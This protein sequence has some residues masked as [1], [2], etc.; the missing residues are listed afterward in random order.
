M[1]PITIEGCCQSGKTARAEGGGQDGHR[2]WTDIGN[3][4]EQGR[5]HTPEHDVGRPM[6][7]RPVASTIP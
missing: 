7:Y 2:D 5:Q 3:K 4:P 1:R 6:K